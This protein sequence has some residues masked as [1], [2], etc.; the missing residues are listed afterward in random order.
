MSDYLI[1]EETLTNLADSVRTISGE[2]TEMTPDQMTLTINNTKN[3]IDMLNEHISDKNNPH[4]ITSESIGAAPISLAIPTGVIVMW[5]GAA[6]AIPAGWVL[7]NGNNNT[8]NLVDRFIVGAGSTYSV[9]ATG[10]SASVTLSTNEMPS[11]THTFT[12]KAHN[13]TFTGTAHGHT[14]TVSLSGLKAD[15][16]GNHR[17]KLLGTNSDPSN[18]TEY[19][20]H[21]MTTHYGDGYTEYNGEHTHTISGSA[22]AT[23]NSSTATGTIANSTATGTNS[24]TGSGKAHENRPPYY[25]LCFIMKT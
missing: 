1:K 11:H 19:W 7:C 15:S 17:H 24:N 4:G 9:G 22:T 5:S 18:A 13:H 8:P 23:I 21:S 14:A 10:G 2:N 6:N 16:A 3:A 25:A 12:G 20:C